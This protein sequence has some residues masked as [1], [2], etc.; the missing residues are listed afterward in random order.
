MK[1]RHT[2]PLIAIFRDYPSTS[3]HRE[4]PGYFDVVQAVGGLPVLL[5]ASAREAEIHACLEGAEG[6]VLDGGPDLDPLREI[7]S[8][9]ALIQ[10]AM[11]RRLPLLAIGQGLQQLN[12]AAG[13]T[14]YPSTSE[15]Q[16][17][18]L[19]H[20]KPRHAVLLEPGTRLEEIY[21]R[22]E[23]WVDN[24]HQQTVRRVGDGLRVSGLAPDG[25]IEA[26]EAIEPTWFCLGIQWHPK[27]EGPAAPDLRLFETLIEAC[28]RPLA[29]PARAAQ[30]AV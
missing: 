15:D 13:G 25:V 4:H 28:L 1:A 19:A 23:I 21:E 17:G 5:A 12:T 18:A 9:R 27:T 30:L 11:D 7:T 16:P 14:L 2:R 26:V 29:V 20:S 6:V 3:C 8:A 22:D 10:H 24:D